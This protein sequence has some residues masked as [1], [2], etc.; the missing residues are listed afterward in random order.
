MGDDRLETLSRYLD[1]DLG[2][3]EAARLEEQLEADGALA[4]E[5]EALV[6]IQHGVRSIAE[7]ETPPEELDRVVEPLR[8]GRP[9]PVSVRPWV[10]WLATAAAVVLGA[11]VILEVS[12]TRLDEISTP[13]P[14][15]RSRVS[16]EAASEPFA[17]APLPTSPVPPEERPV[18]AADRILASPVPQVDVDEP[19]A[20]EVLGPLEAD[21]QIQNG[22]ATRLSATD[23]RVPP[24][25]TAGRRPEKHRG[26]GA[27]SSTDDASLH[28]GNDQRSRDSGEAVQ[29]PTEKAG[30]DPW[31]NEM[32][33]TRG[34]LY[35]FMDGETAW[36][37]FVPT[38]RCQSGRYSVRIRVSNT[39]VSD[40]WPVGRPPAAPSQRLCA[41]ELIVGLRVEDV[42]DGEYSAEVVVERRV[43]RE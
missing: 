39:I 17:L 42:P 8:L 24:L 19:P 28:E 34:Q 25:E 38:S 13:A 35:V 43:P 41:A 1:G 7:R 30:I 29:T 18:G 11:S 33:T 2:A 15:Q 37:E 6:A 23:A 21:A 40:V 9:A 27:V 4:A 12:R 26:N 3:A 36:Q 22:A 5:L 14:A 16:E 31:A 32:Q 10:R 20:L